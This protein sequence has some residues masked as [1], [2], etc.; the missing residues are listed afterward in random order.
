VP[1]FFVAFSLQRAS[2][3]F[4]RHPEHMGTVEV[5]RLARSCDRDVLCDSNSPMES[6]E[7]TRLFPIFEGRGT[8]FQMVHRRK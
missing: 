3:R 7:F 4:R 1:G 6:I 5:R 8:D 2:A